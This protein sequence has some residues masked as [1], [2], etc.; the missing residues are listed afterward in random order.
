M[1]HLSRERGTAFFYSCVGCHVE[2]MKLFLN[3][4][5]VDVTLPLDEN[6]FRVT[7]RGNNVEATKVLLAD[8]RIDVNRPDQSNVTPLWVAS[9]NGHLETVKLLL[10]DERE[11]K[12]KEK[13]HCGHGNDPLEQA[14]HIAG[15][16]QENLVEITPVDLIEEYLDRKQV[17][18]KIVELIEDYRKDSETVRRQLRREL[19]FDGKLFFF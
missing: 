16:I 5:R 4:P 19:C 10:A 15:R 18:L 1:N 6:P 17:Y 8:K 13:S 12:T 11:I 9:G 14:V 7:C 2:I 3:D